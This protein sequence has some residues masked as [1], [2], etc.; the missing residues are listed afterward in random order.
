MNKYTVLP[1]A[2]D[3]ENISFAEISQCRGWNQPSK[4]NIYLWILVD[5]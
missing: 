3:P 2:P 4:I 5:K 1:N